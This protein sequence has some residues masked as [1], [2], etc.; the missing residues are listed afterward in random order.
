[1]KL[2]SIWRRNEMEP[3]RSFS[4]LQ[5]D[6]DRFFEDFAG[7]D[8]KLPSTTAAGFSPSCEL[9]EDKANYIMKFD[10]PGVRKED[11]KVEV[12]GNYLTVTAE[13]REEKR[14][15]DRKNRYSE[16]NYGSYQRSC[17]LPASVDDK[18]VDAKF[19]NG[20]LTLTIPKT[21]ETKAK[22]IAVH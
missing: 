11:V 1:M 16:I 15:E 2:P 4:R 22:Q 3:F 21:E 5:N 7:E 8:I 13:R 10:M 18:K 20:V 19:D 9:S 17:A 12:D 6:L 14:S